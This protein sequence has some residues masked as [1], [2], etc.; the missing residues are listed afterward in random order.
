[1]IMAIDYNRSPGARARGEG[2]VNAMRF[3]IGAALIATIVAMVALYAFGDQT[4]G[5]TVTPPSA[6][7]P[8]TPSPPS[9]NTTTAPTT[10]AAK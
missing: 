10:P 1:M 7:E 3:V 2:A 6:T 5:T 4:I 9:N 8:Q